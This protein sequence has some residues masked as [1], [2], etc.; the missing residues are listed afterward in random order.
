MSTTIFRPKLDNA[1]GEAPA[2]A[3]PQR[4][5]E[6]PNVWSDQTPPV[7]ELE[8]GHPEILVINIFYIT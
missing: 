1:E 6:A 7:E 3:K 2:R 5:R 8:L 4:G